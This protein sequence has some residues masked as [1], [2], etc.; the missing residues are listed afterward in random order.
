MIVSPATGGGASQILKISHPPSASPNQLQSL[1]QSLITGK[2]PDG[3]LIQ[4][5]QTT[6]SAKQAIAAKTSVGNIQGVK[7]VQSAS[8]KRTAQ[9]SQQN[10]NV[11]IGV[12]MHNLFKQIIKILFVTL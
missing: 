3:S 6:P 5:R 4:I 8:G 2:S 9:N 1:A 11:S 12:F 10:R 7:T